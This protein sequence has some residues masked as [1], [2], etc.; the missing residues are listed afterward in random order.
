ML[1]LTILYYHISAFLWFMLE[2]WWKRRK[3][4]TWFKL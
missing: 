4:N 1:N 2:S 3:N